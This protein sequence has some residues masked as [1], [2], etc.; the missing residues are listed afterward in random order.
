[1]A[2]C[3]RCNPGLDGDRDEFSSSAAA[4]NGIAEAF[5]VRGGGREAMTALLKGNWNPRRPSPTVPPEGLRISLAGRGSCE[6][7]ERVVGF[8]DKLSY[9][10]FARNCCPWPNGA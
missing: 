10:A 3:I 1:M 6:I 2:D 5:R 4:D 8:D 7:C 9:E